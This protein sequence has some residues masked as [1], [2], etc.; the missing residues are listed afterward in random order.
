MAIFS[1][2]RQPL[3]ASNYCSEWTYVGVCVADA[4]FR[5]TLIGKMRT[6]R[7]LALAF[8][9]RT[10]LTSNLASERHFSRASSARF[11]IPGA[12]NGRESFMI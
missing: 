8:P 4:Y 9:Q 1:V 11:E 5:L 10:R 12:I 6:T 2:S 7:V 3:A